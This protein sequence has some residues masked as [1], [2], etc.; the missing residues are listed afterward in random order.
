MNYKFTL[1][2]V[3][4]SAFIGGIPVRAA[5]T[6][7]GS[8]SPALDP[9]GGDYGSALTVGTDDVGGGFR[10]FVFADGGTEQTFPNMIVGKETDYSGQVTLSADLEAGE[11]TRLL[12]DSA[13]RSIIGDQGTGQVRVASGASL[14]LTN[15]NADLVLGDDGSGVGSLFVDGSFS[16]VALPDDH[17]IGLNGVG[18]MEITNG[19]LVYN[20][21]LGSVGA[22]ATA[23]L[24]LSQSGV[25]NVLVNGSESL[26][27]ID[28]VLTVGGN[29]VGTLTIS[30]SALVSVGA[31]NVGPRGSVMMH[32]GMLVA[33]TMAINGYLGG[34]GLVDATIVTNSAAIV[35]AQPNG[36][37][38]FAASFTNQ[39]SV[40]VDKG[41]VVFE[42]L[43]TNEPGDVNNAAG[44]ISLDDGSLAFSS[45]L[46]NSGIIATLAGAN[47]LHGQINNS[48]SGAIVLASNSVGSFYDSV[49]VDNGSL[50][51]LAGANALFLADLR[52]DVGG[53]ALV[54]LGGGS[55][56]ISQMSVNGEA[57]LAGTLEVEVT[58][59][60]PQAGDSFLILSSDVGITGEFD[61]EILPALGPGLNW[62]VD[63]REK[64]VVLDVVSGG[65][66]DFN[67]DGITNALDFLVWQRGESPS[68]LSP[69]D[70]ALWERDYAQGSLLS[71]SVETV[72]EPTGYAIAV[73][74]VVALTCFR[75]RL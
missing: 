28:D 66:S 12:L 26:W 67:R 56:D 34:S 2:S 27:R 61:T 1:L 36:S 59:A 31:A 39:G 44:R 14:E 69:S 75:I 42:G 54:Q 11:A 62:V 17:T 37:L 72:P 29:G 32:E 73:A 22:T 33:D 8:V 63:Y 45:T 10:G 53:V 24:G 5:V 46:T 47:Y 41:A 21:N 57:V 6:S 48:S 19:G 64:S 71:T 4:F 43:F 7:I 65:S 40:V 50:T 9:N 55:S 13:S 58:G 49:N 52:F 74:M 18:R 15:S 25:G 70:L 16:Y 30:D 20:Q 60:S 38:R 35:E 51:L 68:P 23:T 3:F